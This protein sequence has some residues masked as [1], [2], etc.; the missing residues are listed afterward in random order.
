LENAGGQGK[1]ASWGRENLPL[2]RGE[3]ESGLERLNRGS[4][5]KQGDGERS[6]AAEGRHGYVEFGAGKRNRTQSANSDSPPGFVELRL[7]E[8]KT[9]VFPRLAPPVSLRVTL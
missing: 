3:K 9:S 1:I 7:A 8:E 4:G 5:R 2:L 6:A